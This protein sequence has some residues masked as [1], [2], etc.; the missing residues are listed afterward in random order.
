M[1]RTDVFTLWQSSL[2]QASCFLSPSAHTNQ[3][4]GNR[5]LCSDI[6]VMQ[7]LLNVQKK[8]R[9]FVLRNRRTQLCF[10]P[11][12]VEPD[13]CQGFL[14]AWLTL[15][16][17][18]NA[19]LKEDARPGGHTEWNTGRMVPASRFYQ[20]DVCVCARA[21]LR[22]TVGQGKGWHLSPCCLPWPVG[23]CCLC[24]PFINMLSFPLTFS[25]CLQAWFNYNVN[26]IINKYGKDNQLCLYRR[27]PEW[28]SFS[29][30]TIEM[31]SNN[32]PIKGG[33]SLSLCLS[34][35][36]SLFFRSPLLY[37]HTLAVVKTLTGQQLSSTCCHARSS[38]PH[39]FANVS[40]LAY[41]HFNVPVRLEGRGRR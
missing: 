26:K 24:A 9:F 33:I 3:C 23:L 27:Y 18:H 41:L 16:L 2:C 5:I 38:K 12:R 13:R 10:S 29:R 19:S 15:T 7:W 17:S 14:M 35:S 8:L 28:L 22:V 25:A 21:C 1:L 40:H 20:I 4:N 31:M 6:L 36:L 39:L 34:R 32:W 30:V 37:Y 11:A